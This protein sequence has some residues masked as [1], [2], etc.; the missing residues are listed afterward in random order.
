MTR[1]SSSAIRIYFGDGRALHRVADDRRARVLGGD[2][3]RA[4]RAT[5]D[6]AGG[7][8]DDVLARFGHW[9]DPIARLIE[10]TPEGA[11][12]RTDSYARPAARTW[13][14]GA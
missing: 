11:I 2:L 3:A 7:K 9:V 12:R 5:Q 10:A 14:A 8:K 13:G 1:T 4:R 6:G